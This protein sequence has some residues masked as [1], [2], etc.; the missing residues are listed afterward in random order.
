MLRLTANDGALSGFD[1]VTVNEVANQAPV[2][3][4]GPDQTVNFPTR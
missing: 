2:V 3:N 4:A 1:E